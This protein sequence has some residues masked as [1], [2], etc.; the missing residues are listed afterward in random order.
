MRKSPLRSQL[1]AD[2][3]ALDLGEHADCDCGAVPLAPVCES[4]REKAASRLAAPCLRPRRLADVVAHGAC[5]SPGALP[6]EDEAS[7]A[8]SSDGAHEGGRATNGK[9][10]GAEGLGFNLQ[11]FH[12][13]TLRPFDD[14]I[15]Y[16]YFFL[17][18]SLR[19]FCLR[20]RFPANVYC[21]KE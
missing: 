14:G 9:G 4:A 16:Y 1:L 7:V 3:G 12:P 18:P 17:A 10:I 8:A 15:V 19:I 5:R 6:F 11:A 20:T 2:L 21:G 13:D